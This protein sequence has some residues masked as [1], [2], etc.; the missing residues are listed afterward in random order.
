MYTE[1]RGGGPSDSLFGVVVVDLH[2]CDQFGHQLLHGVRAQPANLQDALVVDAVC[3]LI[4]LH[5]LHE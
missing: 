1:N 5:H 3:V 2:F 4:A